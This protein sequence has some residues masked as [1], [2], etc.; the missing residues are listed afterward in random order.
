MLE[1]PSLVCQ[2]K[3]QSWRKTTVKI[4]TI[5]KN[6]L[7]TQQST[8]FAQIKQ[9]SYCIHN[10]QP[11]MINIQHIQIVIRLMYTFCL[12]SSKRPNK[13]YFSRL[14]QLSRS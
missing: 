8:S 6:R 3:S 2:E 1:I 4:R 13:K 9:K 10:I 14:Y 12:A 7:T 5:K 11:L